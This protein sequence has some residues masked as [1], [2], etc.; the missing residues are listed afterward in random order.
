MLYNS[1]GEYVSEKDLTTSAANVTSS[2]AAI[3]GYSAK[4]SLDVTL[5]T[6]SQDFIAEYGEPV[7]GYWFHTSALA[8][9]R[10]GNQLYCKRVVNGALYG[11]RSIAKTGGTNYAF[12]A[13]STVKTFFTDSNYPNA[14]FYVFGKD[15]GVWNN[16]LKVSIINSDA[17]NYG[18][19]IDVYQTDADGNDIKVESWDVSRKTVLDGFGNQMYLES[20]INGFSKYIVV[21]DNTSEADTEL[22]VYAT[23][24]SVASGSSGNAVTDTIINQGWA[25]FANKDEF[26]VRLLINAG[27]ATITVQN[28]MLALAAA[29]KDCEALLDMPTASMASVADMV[30]YRQTTLAA[31]NSYGELF[32]PCLLIQD[33][34]T[35]KLLAVPPSG[36]AAGL[37]AY[38]NYV[39][40]P[41]S[42]AAGMTRANLS[43]FPEV[44]GVCDGNKTRLVFDLGSRDLLDLADINYFQ[45]FVGRGRVLW[46]EDTLQAK[47]SALK[48][49]HIRRLLIYLE[50]SLAP[51]LM[52][53]VF[54]P[55]D[56]KTRFLIT[57]LFE[58]FLQVASAKGAFQLTSADPRGYQVLCN[59]TN[60]T[61][62]TI[63]REEIHVDLFIKPIRVG[64]YIPFQV[65]ITSTGV[66]ISEQISQ[67]VMF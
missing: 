62:A 16:G 51:T 45:S 13:G 22:P 50:T 27:Y 35:G 24:L 5:I 23:L 26:D 6:N 64:K 58:Q 4:G 17:A 34:Y 3:A 42:A 25:A 43:I 39:G 41:W 18:F 20:K 44:V 1:A 57:S 32:A 29:R 49:A 61:P 52:D 14:L 47:N 63:D 36:Y 7:P 19:R 2:S 28:Y 12:V 33:I 21:A 15:P 55:N 8:Y 40:N 11:G 38:S 53:F 54:E 48:S 31:D 60:N 65:I 46:N 30:T 37:I 67:G 59:E 9:L 66:S 10:V 56:S